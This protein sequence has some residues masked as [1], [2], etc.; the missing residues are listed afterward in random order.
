MTVI[1]VDADACPVKDEIITIAI[2]HDCRAIMVCNGGIVQAR[3]NFQE[4]D[5]T[6]LSL[7]DEE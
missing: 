2:R 4:C 1:Y 6:M 3:L 7:T 5:S